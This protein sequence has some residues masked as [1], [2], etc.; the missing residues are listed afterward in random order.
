MLNAGRDVTL[1]VNLSLLPL[2]SRVRIGDDS[3]G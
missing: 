1:G 2:F 3:L